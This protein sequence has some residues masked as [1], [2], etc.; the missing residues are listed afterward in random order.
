MPAL[1]RKEARAQ[2]IDLLNDTVYH[3]LGLKESLEEERR[4]LESQDVERIEAAV[5]TKSICVKNLQ[6]LDQKRLQLCSASGFAEDPEQMTQFITWCDDDEVVKSRWE[7]LML[8]AAESAALNLTNGAII[9]LRQNQF[10][11]SL[12]L[13]RGVTAGADTYGKHGEE[14]GGFGR[15]SLAEA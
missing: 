14:S 15:Q 4:A 5:E 8:V 3:A 9:R 13:L 7:Y 2:F 6:P 11:S 12:A 10:D 1:S